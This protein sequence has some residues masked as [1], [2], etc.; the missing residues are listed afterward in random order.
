MEHGNPPRHH[1]FYEKLHLS[2]RSFFKNGKERKFT[3]E[4]LKTSRGLALLFVAI[5]LAWIS[6][7]ATENQATENY[8]LNHWP[9]ESVWKQMLQNRGLVPQT[10]IGSFNALLKNHPDAYS[11]EKR[12]WISPDTCAVYLTQSPYRKGPELWTCDSDAKAASWKAL[13]SGLV[14]FEKLID[15]FESTPKFA[16]AAP[17]KSAYKVDPKEFHY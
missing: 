4:T 16:K 3:A 12:I 10:K 8:R 6:V 5:I 9:Q 17:R 7:A 14:G 11:E 15:L 13:G 1:A 2:L